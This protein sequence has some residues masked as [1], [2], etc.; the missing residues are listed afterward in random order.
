ME[1]L[2]STAFQNKRRSISKFTI[3]KC[4]AREAREKIQSVGTVMQE[5]AKENME[6][7]V[8]PTPGTVVM[9]KKRPHRLTC[10][11]LLCKA[12]MVVLFHLLPNNY[13]PVLLLPQR[14]PLH[15]QIQSAT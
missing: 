2:I 15:R 7:M 10:K 5:A 13:H 9:M 3:R 14:Y 11:D 1:D 4:I 12:T 8:L 6:C